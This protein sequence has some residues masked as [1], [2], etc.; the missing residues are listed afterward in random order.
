MYYCLGEEE[1]LIVFRKC[2]F[3]KGVGYSGYMC[4]GFYVL[5]GSWKFGSLSLRGDEFKVNLGNLLV[6]S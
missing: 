2:F 4:L 3:R 6:L 5:L 1:R